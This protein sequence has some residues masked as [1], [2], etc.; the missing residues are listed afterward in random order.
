MPDPIETKA[1]QIIDSDK[2]NILSLS[3]KADVI[4]INEAIT[5]GNVVNGKTSMPTAG[6]SV[7]LGGSIVLVNGVTV[8]A[9]AANT[10]P[11]FVGNSTVSSSNGYELLAGE[12]VFVACDNLEDV[13]VLSGTNNQAVTY[14]GG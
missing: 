6:T 12:S 9:L 10:A 8:K 13:F 11:V 3:D 1:N 4:A 2:Q 7:A 14:I 5:P